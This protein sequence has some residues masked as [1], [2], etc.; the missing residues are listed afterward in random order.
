[1]GLGIIFSLKAAAIALVLILI[2][3][4]FPIIFHSEL[5]RNK[6]SLPE[7]IQGDMESIC[8]GI[9]EGGLFSLYSAILV[10]YSSAPCG[11]RVANM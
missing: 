2:G 3:V 4:F 9:R 8:G 5:I 10:V 1:M 11:S 6:M 7:I